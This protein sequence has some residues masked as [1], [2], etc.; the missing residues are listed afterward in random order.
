MYRRRFRYTRHIRYSS[1]FSREKETCLETYVDRMSS[2]LYDWHTYCTPTVRLTNGHA[3]LI[4]PHLADAPFALNSNREIAFYNTTKPKIF[5][6]FQ[7]SLSPSL[8]SP[9]WYTIRMRSWQI[10][11]ILTFFNP[12]F[13]S[14]NAPLITMA[15]TTTDRCIISTSNTGEECT[16]LHWN[17]VL[18]SRYVLTTTHKHAH[19]LTVI[20]L[21]LKSSWTCKR[22]GNKEPRWLYKVSI[23]SQSRTLLEQRNGSDG[24]KSFHSSK[25][26][27]PE[28]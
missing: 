13:H 1:R 7:V 26:R 23:L 16:F 19:Y 15:P 28:R 10:I 11:I 18:V 9:W 12:P 8:V 24:Y 5:A 17:H 2:R 20:G 25:F 27:L 21:C 6:E 3:A 22:V 14:R 4:P